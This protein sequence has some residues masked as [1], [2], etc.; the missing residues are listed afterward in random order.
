[1]LND[2]NLLITTLITSAI[3]WGPSHL[4]YCQFH[5]TFTP[6]KETPEDQLVVCGCAASP[7]R[8]KLWGMLHQRHTENNWW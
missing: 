5:L 8:N 4:H 1:M 3:A 2:Y 7:L 6:L